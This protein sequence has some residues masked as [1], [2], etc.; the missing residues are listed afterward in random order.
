MVEARGQGITPGLD[1]IQTLLGLLDHPEGTYPT[2]HLAGTNGKTSTARMVGAILAAHGLPA[3]VYTSPHLQTLRERFVLWGRAEE[4]VL[5]GE[6]ISQDEFR[7]LVEYLLPFVALVDRDGEPVTYFE[8]TTALAF[9]WLAQ[10]TVAAGVIETGLGGSW[11]ATNVAAGEVAVLTRIGVDHRSFLG[12]TPLANA[13]EKVGILKPGMRAVSAAQDADVAALV[14]ATAEEKGVTLAVMG[15]DFELVSDALAL[16]GR[17][18]TV[19]GTSGKTYRELFLPLLGGFQSLNATLAIAACEELLGRELDEEAVVDA[20][21]AVTSPGRL[22]LVRRAPPTVLDG[23]HNPQ[24]AQA[25]VRALGESFGPAPLTFVVSIFADK[26]IDQV[27]GPLLAAAE[28]IIF[29]ASSSPRAAPAADLAEAARR[30]GADPS[31]IAVAESLMAALELADGQSGAGL[32]VVTGS[33]YAVGEA[34][35]L[36]LGSLE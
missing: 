34:R 21:G 16:G 19:R 5:S 4:G 6:A 23:A 35:D 30:L 28:R 2:V 14:S 11:D 10:R 27:L 8:L 13:R 33:L 15:R 36:I 24:A 1:R 18:I 25:L 31:A 32:I 3:G 20:L 22:E 7:A 26:D 12:S 29:W 17:Q 9:E